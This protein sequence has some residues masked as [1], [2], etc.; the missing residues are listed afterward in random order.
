MDYVPIWRD[1]AARG[2]E[3]GNHTLFHPCRS[4]PPNERPLQDIGYNLCHYTERR[5]RDEIGLANWILTQVDGRSERT[6]ANTCHHN[7]IG[8]GANLQSLEPILADYFVAARGELTN[9]M[10]DITRVNYMNLGTIGAD[11]RSFE[12][13][14]DEITAAVEAGNWVIYTMHGVGD[15]THRLFIDADEHWR[16]VEWLGA[17]RQRIWTAPMLEVARHLSQYENR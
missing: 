17:N 10:I 7:S 9:Q 6:Y 1:V 11:G 15:G 3:L 14:K 4:E 5:F 16:L 12:S 13:L 8:M 2:H